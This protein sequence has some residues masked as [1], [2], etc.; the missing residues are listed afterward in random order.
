[1]SALRFWQEI[2]LQW[3]KHFLTLRLYNFPRIP[4]YSFLWCNL[5]YAC[6]WRKQ[7]IEQ[8]LAKRVMSIRRLILNPERE[9]RGRGCL[10]ECW[11]KTNHL[12]RRKISFLLNT[13][14]II[15]SVVP[16]PPP[17]LCPCSSMET[18]HPLSSVNHALTDSDLALHCYKRFELTLH[19]PVASTAGFPGN[20]L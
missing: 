14:C 11:R 16:S 4:I 17:P 13:K 12:K 15:S 2:S 9:V 10:R 19:F 6:D 20:W 8:P 3:W 7:K 1:M 5:A 18:K